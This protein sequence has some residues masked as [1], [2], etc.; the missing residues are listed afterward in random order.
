MKSRLT[1]APNFHFEAGKRGPKISRRTVADRHV[2]RRWWLA[3]CQRVVI[4]ATAECWPAFQSTWPV[5]SSR[6]WTRLRDWRHLR[7]WDHITDA[8]VCL[9]WLC[10]PKRVQ[11][12]L[13]V[14]VHKVLHGLAP[15]YFA[16]LNYGA[17]LPGCRSPR[18][19]STNRPTVPLSKMITVANPQAFPTVGQW[20]WNDL[21]DDMTFC[22]VFVHFPQASQSSFFSPNQFLDCTLTN[23]SIGLSLYC[24]VHFRKFWL[25]EW[26]KYTLSRLCCKVSRRSANGPL[27]P[28]GLYI[29]EG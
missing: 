4:T 15:A 10:V 29:I 5:D 9:N 1:L 24:L 27:T 28:V 17:D 16:P 12:N 19:A 22:G 20:T 8:L 11:Y 21:P 26:L 3:W 2:Q 6:C 23:F 13:A 14:L 7:R 18:S 25:I